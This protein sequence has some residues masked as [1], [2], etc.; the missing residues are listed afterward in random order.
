MAQAG[1]FYFQQGDF[2]QCVY[3]LGI[4]GEWIKDDDPF[5]FHL[6]AFPQ[7]PFITNQ[8]VVSHP[9][10]DF[11][12]C[13]TQHESTNDAAM[14]RRT[15]GARA[16][17]YSLFQYIFSILLLASALKF[18]C[19]NAIVIE[20]LD[21]WESIIASPMLHA[22]LLPIPT[23][24]LQMTLDLDQCLNGI[25]EAKAT[26]Q[27]MKSWVMTTEELSTAERKAPFTAS[28]DDSHDEL[29]KILFD[30][31][32]EVLP[33]SDQ[34]AAV[35]N[36]CPIQAATLPSTEMC[37]DLIN[38]TEIVHDEVVRLSST[39]IPQYTLQMA[40]LADQYGQ[41]GTSFKQFAK[42]L[43]H[44][45][46]PSIVES[47]LTACLN[48]C[49]ESSQLMASHL[50]S[51]MVFMGR[52]T[53][54]TNKSI[55]FAIMDFF[56]P[57]KHQFLT[58]YQ[59]TTLPFRDD[60]NRSLQLRLS[61]ADSTIWIDAYDRQIISPLRCTPHGLIQ[62]CRPMDATVPVQRVRTSF[63]QL[64]ATSGYEEVPAA[65]HVLVPF[66]ATSAVIATNSPLFGSLTCGLNK[67]TIS[68]MGRKLIQVPPPCKLMFDTE[69]ISGAWGIPTP[70]YVQQLPLLATFMAKLPRTRLLH[71]GAL[72]MTNDLPPI[73]WDLFIQHLAHYY[74]FYV[75]TVFVIITI[76]F[77]A[78]YWRILPKFRFL[79]RHATVH[80]PTR[81]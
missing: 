15:P 3:C 35:A 9:S 68:I 41:L 7:C 44:G 2:V 78:A 4:T 6:E 8:A 1:F 38:M 40:D 31:L 52:Q 76:A 36:K 23:E 61:E 37:L 49:A 54:L 34:F 21:T 16:V 12:C 30:K 27:A 11:A 77:G 63:L 29:E 71:K 70:S 56:C 65:Q 32:I 62:L 17:K 60:H 5:A 66:N 75:L 19:M 80:F 64:Q 24:R 39:N 69:L 50:F 48:V 47:T 14:A 18:P 53:Q 67:T 26:I 79:L 33:V 43:S 13:C 10:D 74:A 57:T 55:P 73:R 45:I 42:E 58:K 25:T 59:L 81:H 20:E 46:F 72:I 51:H 28:L 22:F